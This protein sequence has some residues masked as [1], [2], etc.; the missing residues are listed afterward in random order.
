MNVLYDQ[1]NAFLWNFTID[2]S[3]SSMLNESTATSVTPKKNI[4]HLCRK[5]FTCATEKF[6]EM[7]TNSCRK[8]PPCVSE[9]FS[10]NVGIFRPIRQIPAVILSHILQGAEI[11]QQ[12][13]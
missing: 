2:N 4:G 5:D 6:S 8:S 3:C 11:F 10:L 12:S 1:I 9:N 7:P 13:Y